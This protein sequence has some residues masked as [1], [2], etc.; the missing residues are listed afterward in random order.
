MAMIMAKMIKKHE[1]TI[2]QSLMIRTMM[3]MST[4]GCIAFVYQHM[5][6]NSRPLSTQNL[7][8]G[9]DKSHEMINL[10]VPPNHLKSRVATSIQFDWS[11]TDSKYQIKAKLLIGVDPND[12]HLLIHDHRIVFETKSDSKE[13]KTFVTNK[14]SMMNVRQSTSLY[15]RQT[16]Q[17]PN[18]VDEEAISAKLFGDTVTIT[19]PK[20]KSDAIRKE[21]KLES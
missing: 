16:I 4:S 15:L 3:T 20:R 21:I 1:R 13:V 17:V 8:K 10:P 12:L 14:E 5:I 19:L 2:P 6:L 11:E 7:Q 18:N 9:L